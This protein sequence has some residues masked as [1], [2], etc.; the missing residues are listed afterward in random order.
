MVDYKI[1]KKNKTYVLPGAGVDI[2]HFA[3]ADY[4]I[5]DSEMKFLFID[6]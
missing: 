5:D 2:E 1:I 3:Y 6:E 4:P